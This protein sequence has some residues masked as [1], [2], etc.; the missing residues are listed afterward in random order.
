MV[1]VVRYA[2]KTYIVLM[3]GLK[4]CVG[5]KLLIDLP[6]NGQIAFFERFDIGSI[7]LATTSFH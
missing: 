2:R 4:H 5:A 1:L 6:I 3:F 7:V